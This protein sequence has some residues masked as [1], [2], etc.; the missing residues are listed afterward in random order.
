[1]M[2]PQ[3]KRIVGIAMAMLTALT[4]SSF[5]GCAEGES[6]QTPAHTHTFIDKGA[7]ECGEPY[8][9]LIVAD[10]NAWSS[11]YY[12][13]SEMTIIFDGA[14]EEEEITYEYD[15]RR[16]V[17]DPVN[18]TVK[19]KPSITGSLPVTVKTA[20]YE[21]T[22]YVHCNTVT[23][24]R[25]DWGVTAPWDDYET[26][27]AQTL[28]GTYDPLLHDSD[29]TLFIGDDVFDQNNWANFDSAY[30][31]GSVPV[32]ATYTNANALAWGIAGSTTY[33][34]E[35]YIYSFNV[36]QRVNPK[37]IVVNVGANNIYTDLDDVD[38]VTDN[39]QRLLNYVHTKLPNVQLYYNA[40]VRGG[41]KDAVV[42]Q[43]NANMRAWC[44]YK[45][46]VTF[47]D[48][49]EEL[50]ADKLEADGAT[51]KKDAY[52][53]V[54]APTLALAGCNVLQFKHYHTFVN[55]GNCTEC[56]APYGDLIVADVNA[57]T[58]ACYG[59]S[60]MTV[61]FVGTAQEEQ[62]TYIY[63]EDK[64]TIDPVNKTVKPKWNVIGAVPVVVKTASFSKRFYVNC[65][66]MDAKDRINSAQWKTDSNSKEGYGN[67]YYYWA[68]GR[69]NGFV[70][71]YSPAVH[72]N[73]V[74]IFIGDSF[75]DEKDYWNHFSTAVTYE[76]TKSA[77]ADVPATFV[78]K[79]ALCWGIGSSTTYDWERFMFSPG[80]STDN[81]DDGANL[82]LDL[83]PKNIV[84]NVG[85]NNIY[86]F[87]EG[88]EDTETITQNLQRLFTFIHNRCPDTNLYY[89]SVTMR[90]SLSWSEPRDNSRDWISA[91]S[92]DIMEEWCR[93]KDWITFVDVESQVRPLQEPRGGDLMRDGLHPAKLAY[94]NIYKPALLA[95][96]CVIEDL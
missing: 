55:K 1:M 61:A 70:N 19:P 10:V 65:Y 59:A 93:Y 7:C 39:V 31:G 45:N 13:A 82:F 12:G 67:G 58:N 35:R 14:A 60:E 57:W 9:D 75:F 89:F 41:N 11:A 25:S 5:F 33:D 53:T 37:N 47:V 56:G 71:N 27:R 30:N 49:E 88:L 22:F 16:L 17:I 29:V 96:G 87:D 83:K 48:V 91:E 3:V 85:T 34:W 92:N 2:K 6:P 68:K 51:P 24:S 32:A 18:R 62:I 69:L 77:V 36:L 26:A 21:K 72:D 46:W 43:T 84:V 44:Q 78:G 50:T 4:A 23:V 81:V 28:A 8:A 63:D 90:D 80:T 74:T 86:L 20:S 40:I 66:Y 95:A 15:T 79:N 94:N 52:N 76:A 64:L 54:I 38:A 73:K 42:A